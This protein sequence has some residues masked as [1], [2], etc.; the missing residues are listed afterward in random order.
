M[1]C[2]PETSNFWPSFLSQS[3]ISQFDAKK[4]IWSIPPFDKHKVCGK[5]GPLFSRFGQL[6]VPLL[7]L[8]LNYHL[9][10]HV[11]LISNGRRATPTSNRPHMGND[12]IFPPGHRVSS[13]STIFF[14]AQLAA[15]HWLYF[16]SHLKILSNFFLNMYDV[17]YE[18]L[19]FE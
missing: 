5:C 16:I 17:C 2:F 12:P 1:T 8:M 10:L 15:T 19:F 4:R 13:K 11:I 6:F 3:H 7:I 14:V 9:H 18:K